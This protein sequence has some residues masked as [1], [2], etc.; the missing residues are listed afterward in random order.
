MDTEDDRFYITWATLEGWRDAN[1]CIIDPSSGESLSSIRFT[2]QTKNQI[3][4][5]TLVPT[6]PLHDDNHG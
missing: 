3:R 5:D 4:K 6:D 2:Q 1:V